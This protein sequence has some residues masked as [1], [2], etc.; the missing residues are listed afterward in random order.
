MPVPLLLSISAVLALLPATLLPL[1]AGHRRDASYWAL[2][3]VAAAG[4]LAVL[5]ISFS[6]GW[7]T[8][9][10]PALWLTVAV[11][12]VIY[13]FLA[14]FTRSGWRL[15]PLLLPYLVLLGILATIWQERPGRPL[16]DAGLGPWS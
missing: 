8:G 14:A 15:G 3:A 6:S 13:A 9:L 2:L 4:P 5:H 7:P 12:L 16:S 10:S 11:S 1:R